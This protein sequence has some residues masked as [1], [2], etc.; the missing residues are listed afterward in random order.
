[1]K[2]FLKNFF[3]WF[4]FYMIL[5]LLLDY[6]FGY[7]T[8]WIPNLLISIITSMTTV[9]INSSR[10]QLISYRYKDLGVAYFT[11]GRVVFELQ[12]LKSYL[13][14][15]IVTE[16]IL[17]YSVPYLEDKTI[18][19]NHWDHLIKNTEPI[20]PITGIQRV[21]IIISLI[22]LVLAIIIF[23]IKTKY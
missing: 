23:L 21:I 3:P 15:M 9:L 11:D 13:F 19:K 10:T 18:Y 5:L 7:E 1:M 12:Y 8:N 20:V 4:I 16:K 6:I 22:L 2:N 17:D 14:G